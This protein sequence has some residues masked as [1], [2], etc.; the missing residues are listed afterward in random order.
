MNQRRIIVTDC[1]E[2]FDNASQGELLL[3]QTDRI[4]HEY[5]CNSAMNEWSQVDKGAEFNCMA[6]R[7]GF[8]YV[9][10]LIYF[11]AIQTRMSIV[12]LLCLNYSELQFR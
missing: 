3:I 11:V 5:Q 12:I 7:Q 8:H 9:L 4:Q 1:I 2:L 10:Y 6:P